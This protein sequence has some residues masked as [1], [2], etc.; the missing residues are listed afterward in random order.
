MRVF[1][2][3]RILDLFNHRTNCSHLHLLRERG[4]V[5]LCSRR[6]SSWV[7]CEY[8]K[9]PYSI[10]IIYN[11]SA[12][13]NMSS[14]LD[15]NTHYYY[16]I[17]PVLTNIRDSYTFTLDRKR[18]HVMFPHIVIQPLVSRVVRQLHATLKIQK[19]GLNLSCCTSSSMISYIL[20]QLEDVF[21][22]VCYD[23]THNSIQFIFIC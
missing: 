15:N 17:L 10:V 7:G 13:S 23:I 16:Y 2:D 3:H 19:F 22:D 21:Q 4:H 1:P 9:P 12:C 5:F 6:M 18:R 20:I 11:T 8:H 14:F